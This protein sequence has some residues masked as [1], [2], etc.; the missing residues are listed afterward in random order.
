MGVTRRKTALLVRIAPVAPD[1]LLDPSHGLGRD[2]SDG[3]DHVGGG[4]GDEP[5]T[6]G[7]IRLV[8]ARP[9]ATLGLP[10]QR[11]VESRGRIGR[12]RDCH[13]DE[14]APSTIASFGVTT[15]TGRSFSLPWRV[16]RMR[17]I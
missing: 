14:C 17:T 2:V 11:H 5:A 16:T 6:D 9:R 8:Q 12:P 4:E 13:P 3:I 1:G 7:G 10:R 15:T